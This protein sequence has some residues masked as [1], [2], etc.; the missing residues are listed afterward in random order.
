MELGRLFHLLVL[1]RERESWDDFQS[2]NAYNKKYP[3]NFVSLVLKIFSNIVSLDIRYEYTSIPP[4]ETN[5]RDY[6]QSP[7][8]KKGGR[9]THFPSLFRWRIEGT[10]SKFLHNFSLPF[11][12]TIIVI[13]VITAVR[14]WNRLVARLQRGMGEAYFNEL[15][16]LL[17]SEKLV[18]LV[19]AGRNFEPEA[20]VGRP[21]Q[22][23]ATH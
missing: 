5:D 13:I 2:L 16:L 9:E 11:S 4:Q 7:L 12:R 17:K 14:W 19:H 21:Q 3:W 8:K 10:S 1:G 6:F 15:L 18:S 22:E 23:G 20:F